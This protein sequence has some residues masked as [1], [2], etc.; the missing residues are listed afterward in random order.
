MLGL[1]LVEAGH[2]PAI[3]AG[4]IEDPLYALVT[5]AGDLEVDRLDAVRDVEAVILLIPMTRAAFDD[6][7]AGFKLGGSLSHRLPRTTL[8]TWDLVLGHQSNDLRR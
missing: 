5:R 8:A 4:L 3:T 7:N 6:L 1:L 2:H